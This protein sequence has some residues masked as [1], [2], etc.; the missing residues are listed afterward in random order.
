MKQLALEVGVTILQPES[1]TIENDVE[2][3]KDTMIYPSTYIAAGTRIGTN[4]Q[5]GPFVYLEGVEVKDNEII[6]FERRVG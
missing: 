4:C 5:I 3:G 1:V 6:R 2:I